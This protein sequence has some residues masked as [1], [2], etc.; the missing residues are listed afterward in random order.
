M[1]KRVIERK[2]EVFFNEKK[3]TIFLIVN[4]II[5]LKAKRQTERAEMI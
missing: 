2:R 1:V 4:K 3:K 5:D